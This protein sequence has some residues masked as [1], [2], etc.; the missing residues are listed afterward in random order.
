[1][2][3]NFLS[4]F[5]KTAFRTTNAPK[6][7]GKTNVSFKPTSNSTPNA[8]SSA[9]NPYAQLVIR[10]EGYRIMV[11]TEDFTKFE[12]QLKKHGYLL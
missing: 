10:A 3:N 4:Q 7:R 11:K 8:S 6:G 1:M 2:E 12:T 9:P 5:H